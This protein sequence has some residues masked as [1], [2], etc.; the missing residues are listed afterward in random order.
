MKHPAVEDKEYIK[1][2][3]DGYN[4]KNCKASSHSYVDG[5]KRGR[6]LKQ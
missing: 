5:F 2:F 3:E 4:G 1:G 6:E